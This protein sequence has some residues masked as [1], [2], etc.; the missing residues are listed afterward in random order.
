MLSVIPERGRLVASSSLVAL[1]LHLAVVPAV[2][3]GGRYAPSGQSAPAARVQTP[4]PD[5][6]ALSRRAESGDA[7]A[8]FELGVRYVNGKGVERDEVT[9][10][11]W[12]RKA[13]DQGYLEAQ[14]NLGLMYAD[15][16][17]VAQDSAEA[18]K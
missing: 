14:F 10:V 1:W 2:G 8:Q 16:N 6:A 15:G 5:V 17:G 11:A 3:A 9:A 18:V 4:D 7:A 13:A 12:I